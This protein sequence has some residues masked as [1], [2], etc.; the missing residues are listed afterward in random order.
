M[1]RTILLADADPAVRRMLRRLLAQEDYFV[2]TA[3]DSMAALDASRTGQIDVLL[4]D[5]NL[6]LADGWSAFQKL[7]LEKPAVPVIGMTARPAQL[8]SASSWGLRAVL[9]KPLD[10]ARLLVTIQEC[11]AHFG[12]VSTPAG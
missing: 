6:P 5:L 2:I 9:E 1:K 4:V 8:F 10:L 3:A 12:E 11:L 7:I